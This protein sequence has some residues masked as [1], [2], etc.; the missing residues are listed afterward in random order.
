MAAARRGFAQSLIRGLTGQLSRGLGG[1]AFGGVLGGLVGVGLSILAG[2]L[3]GGGRQ[4][5]D[6][7]PIAPLL[8][9]PQLASLDYASNP[10]SRLFG[11]RAVARGPA[12][13]VEVAYR[14]GAGDIVSAKVATKLGE[15]NGMTL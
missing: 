3:L 9:F 7:A 13:R 14:E 11:G 10:A 4:A 5:L 6:P 15:M 1:G 12:F 8:H 2:R